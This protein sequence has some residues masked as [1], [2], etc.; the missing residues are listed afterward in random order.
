MVDWSKGS[1]TV[2]YPQARSRIPAVSSV[3]A[4]L[5]NFMIQNDYATH[6]KIVIVGH[7]FGAHTAGLA[8]K[9]VQG[10]KIKAV[11]GLDPA[12]PLFSNDKPMERIAS[13]DA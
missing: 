6:D 1:Q 10:G 11:V 8:A 12:G 3:V 4:D 2:A 5:I 13:T 7:S 9:K